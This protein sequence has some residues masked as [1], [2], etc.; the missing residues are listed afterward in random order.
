MKVLCFFG[1][2]VLLVVSFVSGYFL[3][4]SQWN[5]N[6]INKAKNDAISQMNYAELNEK[7]NEIVELKSELDHE[8]AMAKAKI[9]ILEN[10]KSSLLDRESERMEKDQIRRDALAEQRADELLIE[11]KAEKEAIIKMKKENAKYK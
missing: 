1:I 6:V 7:D 3:C 9:E 5:T 4:D 2:V 10:E 11:S 8:R